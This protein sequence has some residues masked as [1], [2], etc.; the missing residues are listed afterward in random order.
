MHASQQ[1]SKSSSSA[2]LESSCWMRTLEDKNETC[3]W[4]YLCLCIL[5]RCRQRESDVGSLREPNEKRGHEGRL[6]LICRQTTPVV[7]HLHL[8]YNLHIISSLPRR[9]SPCCLPLLNHPER[10][11]SIWSD[12]L[13]LS[14]ISKSEKPSK[15]PLREVSPAKKSKP[16]Q[17]EVC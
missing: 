10:R 9:S 17:D 14:I 15:P 8:L 4:L 13:R 16:R 5:C 2:I 11:L 6:C 3:A 12:T 7:L 1:L